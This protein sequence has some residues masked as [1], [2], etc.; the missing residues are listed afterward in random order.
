[1]T[2]K[3]KK[4]SCALTAAFCAVS[5]LCSGASIGIVEA[6]SLAEEPLLNAN[7]FEDD[8]SA[9]FNLEKNVNVN[10]F[11]TAPVAGEYQAV[12]TYRLTAALTDRRSADITVGESTKTANLTGSYSFVEEK[13]FDIGGNQIRPQLKQENR[14][15]TAILHDAQGAVLTWDLAAGEHAVTISTEVE[16][17]VVSFALQA[18]TEL[19]PYA[20]VLQS[21]QQ[22]G[23]AAVD[24]DI[25]MEAEEGFVSS[26]SS[27]S[28]LNDRSSS[29]TTPAG[30]KEIHYNAV[31]SNWK[32]S[33]QW[34]EWPIEVEESG[35]Y[36]IGMRWRQAEKSNDISF[37]R[38]TIDGQ[39]PF[40]E[41][42]A[43][44][45]AYR[46]GWQSTWLGDT[47]V[48]G[49]FYI[50]L[51]AGQQHVLRLEAVEGSYAE[52]FSRTQECVA[53]LNKI[54]RQIIMVTGPSPDK[55]RDYQFSKRIPDTLKAMQ[56][57]VN[58]MV[59]L[60][61]AVRSLT[62]Q[63]ENECISLIEQLVHEVREMYED[64]LTI[65]FYLNSFQA[66]ISAL[67]TWMLSA[68]EQPLEIDRIVLSGDENGL[69]EAETG[70]F[71]TLWF[72]FEQFIHSFLMDYSG[73]GQMT[74]AGDNDVVIWMSGGRDQA[75][76][77]SELVASSFVPETGIGA[78]V[79]LVSASS[80]LPAILAGKGPDV[81]LGMG[82]AEPMN[83]ALRGAVLDLRQFSD[84]EEIETRFHDSALTPFSFN[85]A[86]YALPETQ[87]FPI[88]YYRTDILEEMGI[89]P[90][91]LNTW[92]DILKVVLPKLQESY[93]QF[94]IIPSINNYGML[95]Y[96]RG[97]SFYN[98]EKTACVLDQNTAVQTFTWF[99]TL[100]TD[101]KLDISYDFANRFRTGEMPVAIADYSAYNQLSIYAPEISG[102]WE[103]ALVPG[104][105]Q[106]D[107]TI[108]RTAVSNV[109]GCVILSKSRHPEQAWEFLKWW[110][111]ANT[112][113]SYG[114]SLEQI[115]GT[116]ARY[117]TANRE[118][119]ANLPWSPQMKETINAQW[120]WTRAVPELP[121][122]YMTGRYFDFAWRD[123][124]NN[125]A[126][127]LE[128]VYDAVE[129]IN[130]EIVKKRKEFGLTN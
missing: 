14:E 129:D 107:G 3:M 83:Y 70:F 123:V 121:G 124:V 112:Q 42:E 8:A 127:I 73:V 40:A 100:Y 59:D 85:G 96:Q 34:I 16:M 43:L 92:D 90:D 114:L 6:D 77:L 57:I 29:L 58:E 105:K 47:Q 17:E 25:V 120:E 91:M 54:Y 67:S 80:L 69:P 4:A 94:G 38:L 55:N 2:G 52:V 86:L 109:S 117:S 116:A 63:D 128:S 60:Q 87:V 62:G 108:D 27:V 74:A 68:K 97:G 81:Y 12:L 5:L 98:E 102:L 21:W 101:Y 45:F 46:S 111:G 10:I 32:Q 93:L 20:D 65:A 82:Q 39:V 75:S 76:I 50:Y 7:F 37:R 89:S 44:P 1:M 15:L 13:K 88:L 35:L 113:Q 22:A 51:T 31:G 66:N 110:T 30:Y 119:M 125:N 103:M 23:Y 26:D 56:N 118:A 41:A 49:G 36:R 115:M 48:D 126:D 84:C 19:A 72:L 78:E 95:L 11:V 71:G 79:Q 24:A 106:A 122:S 18:K 9:D 53:N 61:N 64:D 33:G 130:A 104:T 99:T 28:V